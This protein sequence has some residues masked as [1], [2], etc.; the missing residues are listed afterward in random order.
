MQLHRIMGSILFLNFVTVNLT[1]S[2]QDINLLMLEISL[3]FFPELRASFWVF[4]GWL[5][6]KFG[7]LGRMRKKS[8]TLF[9]FFLTYPALATTCRCGA[10]TLLTSWSALA[11]Q[12]SR[13]FLKNLFFLNNDGSDRYTKILHFSFQS[14]FEWFL[15]FFIEINLIIFISSLY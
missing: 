2:S 8:F 5:T 3:S 6:S 11:G 7:V 10:A 1:K 4:L 13:R 12:W 9:T 15:V 14:I